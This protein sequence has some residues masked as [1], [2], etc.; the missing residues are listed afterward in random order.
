MSRPVGIVTCKV[1]PEPD[2][3]H[4]ATDLIRKLSREDFPSSG[5][6]VAQDGSLGKR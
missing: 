2:P 6:V 5:V 3:D 1:L 4:K